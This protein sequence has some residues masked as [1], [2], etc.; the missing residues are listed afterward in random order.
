[1][2]LKLCVQVGEGGFQHL[3]MPGIRGSFELLKNTLT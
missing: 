1:M 3:A 2:I